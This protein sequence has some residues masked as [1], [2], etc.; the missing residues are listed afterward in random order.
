MFSAS[1]IS[2]CRAE[3][4][5]VVAFRTAGGK[6]NFIFGAFAD[7]DVM[8]ELQLIAPMAAKI[9][10]VPIANQFRPSW[11]PH[12]LQAKIAEYNVDL[13]IMTAVNLAEALKKLDDDHR[14]TVIAGSLYLAAEALQYCLGDD[15]ALNI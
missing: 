14:P 3:N 15:S 6:I 8:P 13:E 9:V 1:Y 4:C 10:F 7:K 2:F 5:P 12:E 11:A